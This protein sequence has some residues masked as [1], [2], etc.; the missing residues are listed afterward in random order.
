MSEMNTTGA[1]EQEYER[2]HA[3]F[4]AK[5]IGGR[6]GFG[7]R[8]ALVVV[9]MI[10][11]FTDDASPLGSDAPET[12][13]EIARLLEAAREASIPVIFST[14]H[15]VAD[16]PEA[17]PWAEKIPSQKTLLPGSRWVDVDPRLE[18]APGETVLVKNFA[19]CFAST[20]LA[21]DLRRLG[22]DTVIV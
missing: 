16:L 6:V 11:G 7:D 5:G 1:A 13:A 19:S 3:E 8:P 9:D 4:T 22:V 14:C 15:Y 21:D 12:I 18:P 17:Q 2:L 10:I 20:T